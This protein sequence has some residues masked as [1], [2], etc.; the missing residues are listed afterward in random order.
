[1]EPDRRDRVAQRLERHPV[2]ARRELELFEADPFLTA[3]P[4]DRPRQ[5]QPGVGLLDHDRVV[6]RADD[7][8][9]R[10]ACQRRE[11]RRQAA[12]HSPG[13]G[14]R[15][16]RRRAAAPA[17]PPA[18]G[19]PRPEPALRPRAARRAGA[20]R[21]ARPTEAI[22]VSSLALGVSPRISSTSSTFSRA[23]R[24][25]TRP[26]CWPHE[27]DLRRRSSARPARSSACTTAPQTR[28]SPASG[29]S[30]PA[31]RWSSVV[32]PEPEG[33]V[34]AV[35]RAASNDRLETAK[36]GSEP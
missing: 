30:S 26:L 14:G 12:A 28:I 27:R 17:A 20:L 4:T 23:L 7:R 19:R 32:L 16:A 2:V 1:M 22:S 18:R 13:R 9:P 33:P 31:S 24:N 15:S 10:L 8:G 25:G 21:S 36:T 11:Q 29:R 3:Q 6:R 34:T 35:T 5:R